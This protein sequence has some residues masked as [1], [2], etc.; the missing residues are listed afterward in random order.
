MLRNA[1]SENN[2]EAAPA[3]ANPDGPAKED[4]DP[5]PEDI[6]LAISKFDEANDIC[7]DSPGVN[8]TAACDLRDKIMDDVKSRGWCWNVDDTP[9]AN[10]KWSKCP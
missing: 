8:V 7:R 1:V 10:A 2:L 6:K 5:M 3:P 9:E 4:S